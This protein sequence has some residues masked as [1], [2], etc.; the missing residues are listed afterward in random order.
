[1]EMIFYNF[2]IISDDA[3]GSSFLEIIPQ[4]HTGPRPGY[5]RRVGSGG[6]SGVKGR[7]NNTVQNDLLCRGSLWSGGYRVWPVIR[8][9]FGGFLPGRFSNW[10]HSTDQT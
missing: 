1:M 8:L 10:Q 7:A 6:A 3:F 9:L 4:P 5:T 2:L